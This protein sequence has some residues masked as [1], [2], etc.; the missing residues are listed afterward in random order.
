MKCL[1]E[2][3]HNLRLTLIKLSCKTKYIWQCACSCA[4]QSDYIS[5]DGRIFILPGE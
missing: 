1:Q 2:L 3:N 4:V 5:G